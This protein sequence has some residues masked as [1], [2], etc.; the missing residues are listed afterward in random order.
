MRVVV[1][2]IREISCYRVLP[3]A[4]KFLLSLSPPNRQSTVADWAHA[5]KQLDSLFTRLRKER[6]N[7]KGMLGWFSSL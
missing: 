5:Q 2:H 4:T 1:Q 3:Y 6:Y 7:S